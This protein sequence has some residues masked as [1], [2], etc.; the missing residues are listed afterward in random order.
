MPS[1]PHLPPNH[2]AQEFSFLA[3]DFFCMLIH[4]RKR[5][6]KNT[7]RQTIERMRVDKILPSILDCNVTRKLILL[8]LTGFVISLS[9]QPQHIAPTDAQDPETQ[10]Q[11]F[12]LPPGFEIQLV[13]SEPDIGQPMNLNFDAQGRLWVTSSVEYP[14]PAQTEGLD[15]RLERLPQV[16]DASPSDWLTVASEIG[17][18]GTPGHVQRFAEG[19]NIPIGQT[20]VGDGGNAI[21]YS[22]PDISLYQDEDGDGLA[23]SRKVLYSHFGNIDTHGMASSFRRWIDGWI[24]GCHGFRNTSAIID[25]QGETTDLYSGH[26]YRFKPD[27]SHF[28]I[29]TRGQV[30]PFGLAIDPLGNIFS[31][32]CHSRPLYQLLQSAAYYRP[33][34]GNPIDEPLGLAPEMIDHDHGSTSISGPAY[35]AADHFPEDYRDNLFLCNSVTRRVH[36]D[37]LVQYGSTL[38]ADTQPDFV[39]C[40]DPWFRPVDVTVGPDGAL[41]IADFYNAIIGH[42]E[43]PLDHPKRDRTHGRVWRVVYKGAPEPALDLTAMNTDEL[44]QVLDR[45][46]EPLRIL[47]NH[48]II[49]RWEAG[50]ADKIVSAFSNATPNAQAH[51]LWILERKGFLNSVYAELAVKN[52]HIVQVHAMKLLAERSRWGEVERYAALQALQAEN[53]FVRRAAADGMRRHPHAVFMDPLL[54]TWKNT[55]SKDTHLIHVLRM[56]IREQLIHSEG[57][58]KGNEG[59]PQLIEI[60]AATQTPEAARFVL[61]ESD[62]E[63]EAFKTSLDVNAG[64]LTE[65]ELAQ[66]IRRLS[67]ARFDTDWSIKLLAALVLGIQSDPSSALID[68]AERSI[69][70]ALRDPE[71]IERPVIDLALG[72]VSHLQLKDLT[73]IVLDM[74][75]DGDLAASEAL[76]SLDPEM[77]YTLLLEQLALA[78][79]SRQTSLAQILSSSEAGIERLLDAIESGQASAVLLRDSLIRQQIGDEHPRLTALLARLPDPSSEIPQLIAA[80]HQGYENADPSVENGRGVFNLQCAVCHSINREGGKLGP[81]LDGIHVRGVER[82]L[83]DILD[84]NRN[85][86]PAFMLTTVR[87][88][89][90]TNVS[91]IGAR[92]EDGHIVLTDPAGKIHSIPEDGVVE[93]IPSHFSMMP[94]TYGALIP[95]NDLYDL[96]EFLLANGTTTSLDNRSLRRGSSRRPR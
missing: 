26:T 9:G 54:R 96:V 37:K 80:R 2:V 53:A 31:A 25:A 1:Y 59:N 78:P 30:N 83:E 67:R 63:Q 4:L 93:Q 76:A 34:W 16:G 42:Y 28:E 90:G 41:Y 44:I 47:A 81:N 82:I 73:G 92:S 7:L 46:N 12:H 64:Q 8:G 5:K 56:A 32:D 21:V 48:Q 52:S 6:V 35:Y 20:P 43:V 24:Y 88:Q 75:R 51:M 95:E 68:W 62:P 49:D 94:A 17:P 87:T 15:P 11:Q 50:H 91:G 89:N 58:S 72:L 55:D 61:L 60:A 70:T 86:D 3:S 45:D 18:D 65:T 23:D 27:G 39:T 66:L 13:L 57:W 19:L 69:R 33:S 29:Y 40:D 38:I 36:R 84:P 71:S 14:F 74:A 85:V 10:R 22:I 77:S 79:A